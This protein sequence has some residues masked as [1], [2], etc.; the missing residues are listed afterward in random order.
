M[1]V[2]PIAHPAGGAVISH[3]DIT[4]WVEGTAVADEKMETAP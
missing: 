2:A 3:I 1:H 4:V